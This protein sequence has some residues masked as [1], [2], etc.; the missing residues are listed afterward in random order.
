[1]SNHSGDP[2]PVPIGR[3]VAAA[4][5]FLVL[6]GGLAIGLSAYLPREVPAAATLSA[7]VSPCPPDPAS[8]CPGLVDASRTQ[9]AAAPG[10]HL[11]ALPTPQRDLPRPG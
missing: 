11:L 6:V 1:M 2:V 5:L 8:R 3:D 10:L 9:D 4:W 7:G